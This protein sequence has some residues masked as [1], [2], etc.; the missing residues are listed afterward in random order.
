MNRRYASLLLALSLATIPAACGREKNEAAESAE[1]Q[2]ELVKQAKIDE[3]T[4]RKI[5]LERVPGGEIVK[6]ELEEEDGKLLYSFDIKLPGKEG[7]E[8]VHVDAKTGEVLS[9]EHESDAE[10]GAEAAAEASGHE[11]G[12]E[13]GHAAG[14]AGGAGG[15][16]AE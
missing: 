4:A 11:G 16:G 13:G 2:A 10:A 3:A 14:S 5:A 7:V 8:E 1:E 9:V 15:A 12:H 6:S